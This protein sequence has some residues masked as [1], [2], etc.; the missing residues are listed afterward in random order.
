MPQSNIPERTLL[1]REKSR[2]HDMMFNSFMT[3]R[4]AVGAFHSLEDHYDL[5]E[6]TIDMVDG[7]VMRMDESLNGAGCLLTELEDWAFD[8]DSY[9]LMEDADEEGN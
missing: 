9:R 3:L 7:W 5:T 4:D 8:G 2:L 1:E 6:E